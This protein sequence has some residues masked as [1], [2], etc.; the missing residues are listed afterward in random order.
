MSRAIVIIK[1]LHTKTMQACLL[2]ALSL[3]VSQADNNSLNRDESLEANKEYNTI[4]TEKDNGFNKEIFNTVTDS[5][6]RD[7]IKS[8]N[9][10][11]TNDIGGSYLVKIIFSL[12]FVL[13]LAYVTLILIKKY[14]SGG[15]LKELNQSKSIHLIEARKIAPRLTVYLLQVGGVDKKNIVLAQC[16]DNITFYQNSV[17]HSHDQLK[18]SSIANELNNQK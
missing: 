15:I 4:A 5:G 18:E 3:G 9:Y 10:K 6:D 7:D 17:D 2:V 12:I 16:G 14:S 1:K 8:L 13:G 11:T